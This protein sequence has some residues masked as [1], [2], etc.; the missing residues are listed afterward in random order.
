M[1]SSL[2]IQVTLKPPERER[3]RERER[4][5]GIVSG[6]CAKREAGDKASLCKKVPRL[7]PI[8]LLVRVV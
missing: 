6:I 3:E 8:V 4:K 1:L 7:R 5:R 2:Q